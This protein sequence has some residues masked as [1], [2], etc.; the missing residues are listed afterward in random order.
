MASFSLSVKT[1]ERRERRAFIRFLDLL[2]LFLSAGYELTHAWET[3]AEILNQED[4]SLTSKNMKKVFQPPTH[5][6]KELLQTLSEDSKLGNYQRWFQVIQTL[7]LQGAGM[8][9]VVEG[10]RGTLQAEEKNDLES[11]LRRLPTKLQVVLILFF[12]PP[13]VILLILPLLTTLRTF[14]LR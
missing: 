1:E 7:Y 6:M 5:G 9:E 12:F 10:L 8:V 14:G 3:S 4:G 11:H 2:G 13:T